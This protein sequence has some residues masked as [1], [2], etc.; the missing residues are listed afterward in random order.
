VQVGHARDHQGRGS[1]AVRVHGVNARARAP[2][3]RNV[4]VVG[5]CINLREIPFAVVRLFSD[6]IDQQGGT[7]WEKDGSMQG[8]GVATLDCPVAADSKGWDSP[9]RNQIR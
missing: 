6:S 5:D 7:V 9:L 2:A 8:K 4:A 1:G 3:R